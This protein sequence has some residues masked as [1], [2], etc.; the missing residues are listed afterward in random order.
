[1]ARE[2]KLFA[3]KPSYTSYIKSLIGASTDSASNLGILDKTKILV[4]SDGDGFDV[5]DTAVVWL[6]R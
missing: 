1:M 3:T 6:K 2:L 4:N 5:D